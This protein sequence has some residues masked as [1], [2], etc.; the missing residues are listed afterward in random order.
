MTTEEAIKTLK[1]I[2]SN[3]SDSIGHLDK[4]IRK[5]ESH[6]SQ[7]E[8]NNCQEIAL[9]RAQV[10]NLVEA[11]KDINSL[12]QHTMWGPGEK[13]AEISFKALQNYKRGGV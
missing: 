8:G 12:C 13:V 4:R 11:L 1:D 9:L 7:L 6:N 3:L 10:K 5:L 2:C